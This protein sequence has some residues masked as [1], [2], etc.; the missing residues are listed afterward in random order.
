[1]DS[2]LKELWY[3]HKTP[4]VSSMTY[5]LFGGFLRRLDFNRSLINPAVSGG[6]QSKGASRSGWSLI[7]RAIDMQLPQW[8]C[9]FLCVSVTGRVCCEC[10]HGIS[11]IFIHNLDLGS[12]ILRIVSD[13]IV[14]YSRFMLERAFFICTQWSIVRMIENAK[15]F[16]GRVFRIFFKERQSID[17]TL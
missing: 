8:R 12:T 2:A 7:P 9:H 5:K 17:E 14:V 16:L 15:F 1:M 4:K 13:S 3:Y 11:Q 6:R 10:N